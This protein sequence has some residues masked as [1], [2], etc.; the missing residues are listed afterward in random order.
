MI[1]TIRIAQEAYD[2]YNKYKRDQK[3]NL[4]QY[5]VF[6]HESQQFRPRL[7]QDIREGDIIKIVNQRVPADI[8]IFQS[9]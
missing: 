8:V 2:D 1:L 3:L 4:E 7:S 5:Q 6:D 9:K